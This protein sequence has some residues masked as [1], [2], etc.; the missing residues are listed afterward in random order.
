MKHL[1]PPP[2]GHVDPRQSGATRT[3]YSTTVTV[4]GGEANHGRASGRGQGRRW[5]PG[6]RTVIPS[7][8]SGPHG[9]R[10]QNSCW[11]RPTGRAYTAS[12]VAGHPSVQMHDSSVRVTVTLRHDP[13]DGHYSVSARLVAHL[14]G[15]HRL[16]AERLVDEA[17]QICPY[18]RMARRGFPSPIRVQT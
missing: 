8:L 11:R 14:P 2:H 5:R 17:E 12:S 3:I 4:T 6:D 1:H 15:A 7:A 18:A 10:T 16:A 9:G 13:D